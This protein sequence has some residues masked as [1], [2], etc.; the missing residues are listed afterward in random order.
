MSCLPN[1]VCKP[2]HLLSLTGTGSIS[3][4]NSPAKDHVQT[5]TK[6]ACPWGCC[7]FRVLLYLCLLFSWSPQGQNLLG[8]N[9][10]DF[11]FPVLCSP[12]PEKFQSA[13]LEEFPPVRSI[14]VRGAAMLLPRTGREGAARILQGKEQTAF[15]S[16]KH[17]SRADGNGAGGESERKN[18]IA[19]FWRMPFLP[20]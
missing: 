11:R 4:A 10:V 16:L 12:F 18:F 5:Q 19:M 2:L 20:I 8:P 13:A 15:K 9:H 14:H 6:Q 1:T 7:F 17:V 3:K